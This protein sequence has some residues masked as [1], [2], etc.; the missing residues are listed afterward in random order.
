MIKW[1]K[2][3]RALISVSM[4]DSFFYLY[5]LHPA[6]HETIGIVLPKRKEMATEL[7]HHKNGEKYHRSTECCCIRKTNLAGSGLNEVKNHVNCF[8]SSFSFVFPLDYVRVTFREIFLN[9][10]GLPQLDGPPNSNKQF[11]Q[12]MFSKSL[13]VTNRWFL[14]K[15]ADFVSAIINRSERIH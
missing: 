2:D 3:D 14:S 7:N 10:I 11:P 13:G 9:T 15:S 5:P 12:D 6:S 8:Y 1:R 4:T